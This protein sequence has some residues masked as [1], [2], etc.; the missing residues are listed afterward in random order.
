MIVPQGSAVVDRAA[1]TEMLQSQVAWLGMLGELRDAVLNEDWERA[2]Y[3]ARRRI[4]YPQ[5]Y[6]E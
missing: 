6:P 2:M 4:T 1:L 5:P 3:L